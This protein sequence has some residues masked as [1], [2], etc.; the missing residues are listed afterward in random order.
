MEKKISYANILRRFAKAETR[1]NETQRHPKKFSAHD[2]SGVS[3][4]VTEI[5][6]GSLKN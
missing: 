3:V 2:S 4:S 1:T 5:S 6:L